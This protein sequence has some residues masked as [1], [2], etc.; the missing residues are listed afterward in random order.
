MSAPEKR[1]RVPSAY[2][3]FIK[4]AFD[5]YPSFPEST[6]YIYYINNN[7]RVYINL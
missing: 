3:R 2:N 7:Y 1:Q 6:T 5:I 4:S